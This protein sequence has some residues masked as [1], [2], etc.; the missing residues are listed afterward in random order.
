M[1]TSSQTLTGHD[2]YKPFL[3]G[4]HMKTRFVVIWLLISAVAVAQPPERKYL[5]SKLATERQLPFS[6][7]VLAGNTLYIAGTIGV[8][9]TNGNGSVNPKEEARLVMDQIK[10]VVEKAGM[11]MDD[12]VSIQVFCTD[13]NH[14]DSF[15]KVY[16][17]Y[18]RRNYPARA[19]V[20]AGK[21]LF[22][23]RYEVLGIAIK[24]QK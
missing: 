15:N 6:S 17:T 22:G 1:A 4:V 11:T 24:S 16:K 19:F 10:Q 2:I 14:Y 23:A 13:L 18:F 9:A 3:G 21:L 20:G 12:V 8:D 5:S 7:G